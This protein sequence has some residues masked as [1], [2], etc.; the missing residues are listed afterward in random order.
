MLP[1]A[2]CSWQ[3]VG[4]RKGNK[5]CN[6]H[7]ENDL[8]KVCKN[9]ILLNGFFLLLHN[10]YQSINQSINLYLYQVKTHMI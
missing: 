9:S 2:G 8:R 3:K 5:I 4:K 7:A 1:V 6:S 10:A